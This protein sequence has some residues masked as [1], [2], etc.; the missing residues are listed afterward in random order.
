MYRLERKHWWFRA[1]REILEG[2][3][4]DNVPAGGSILDVGCGTGFM[5]EKLRDSYDVHGIDDAEIAVK[6]CHDKGLNFVERGILG[7]TPLSR[8]NY[9]MVMFLD[10][11][12]H[13]DDDVGVLRAA[14]KVLAP[15][16]SV[17]VTVP[18][19]KVLWS[20]HDVVHHH[21]R[22]YDRAMLEKSLRAAGLEPQWMS[23]FNTLL[24][25]LVF[26]ARIAGKLRKSS[27][28]ADAVPPGPINELLYRTFGA[29]RRLLSHV[30][31]PVGV[32]LACI[33]RRATKN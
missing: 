18:A 11:I 23:Y 31:M 30:K 4:R 24:F 25:P 6:L 19:L 27:S 32:S 14:E 3:V 2:V 7:K 13:I 28:D 21:R 16:G 20:E 26:A 17:L 15:N 10:V 29:E 5:L 12:E 22:R 33:A 1:R 9:D 8:P